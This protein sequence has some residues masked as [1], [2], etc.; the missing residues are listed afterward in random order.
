MVSIGALCD[1]Q[2]KASVIYLI[3]GF[4]WVPQSETS[5]FNISYLNPTVFKLAAPY[6]GL[7]NMW[8][9]L[10]FS[11]PELCVWDDHIRDSSYKWDPYT[12]Y[13]YRFLL[14][15]IKYFEAAAVVILHYMNKTE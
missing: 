13:Y 1:L 10:L 4:G 5:H 15:N 12:L 9:G 14:Y 11:Q 2:V 3:L 6:K 8:V 7:K